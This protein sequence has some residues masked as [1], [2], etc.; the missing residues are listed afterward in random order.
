MPRKAGA[1][2]RRPWSGGTELGSGLGGRRWQKSNVTMSKGC[3]EAVPR[4][5]RRQVKLP[6]DRKTAILLPYF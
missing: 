4:L 2:S 5:K 1:R 6:E 3:I